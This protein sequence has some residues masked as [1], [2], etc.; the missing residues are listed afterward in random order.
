VQYLLQPKTKSY[1]KKKEKKRKETNHIPEDTPDSDSG[2]K[3]ILMVWLYSCK[4]EC[5]KRFTRPD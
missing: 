1:F 5:Q 2:L 4:M 3:R